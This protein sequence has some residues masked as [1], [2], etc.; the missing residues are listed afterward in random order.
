MLDA[1]KTSTVV[2]YFFGPQCRACRALWPKFLT[3]AANN[4][5]VTFVKI[6]TTEKRLMEVADGFRVSK[7]PWFLILQ[8][9]SG[10]QLASF[11]ANVSTVS[12]LRAEI[13]AAKAS[14]PEYTPQCAESWKH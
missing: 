10:E 5:D 7:L 4:Q 8:A 13:A 3:I 6:N 9:Q 2:A 11:T 1:S 12:T 14:N